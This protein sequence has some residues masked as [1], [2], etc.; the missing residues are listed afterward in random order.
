MAVGCR[1]LGCL[2][3]QRLTSYR[4]R[5]IKTRGCLSPDYA[6]HVIEWGKARS[7]DLRLAL[8]LIYTPLFSPA[9][10]WEPLGSAPRCQFQTL[11]LKFLFTICA[12]G[13]RSCQALIAR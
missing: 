5:G 9:G 12:Q 10:L 8:Q 7:G 4:N 11:F 6:K 1:C 13:P 3:P 2:E